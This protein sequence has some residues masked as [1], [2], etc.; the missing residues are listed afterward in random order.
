LD[1]SYTQ[2]NHRQCVEI[3]R[4]LLKSV[5][6]LHNYTMSKEFAGVPANISRQLQE[7]ILTAARNV[8]DGACRIIECS[9]ILIGNS[10]E[11]SLWQQLAT[12]TKSVSEAI[13]RLATSVKY[14]NVLI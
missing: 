5:D 7:P 14:V 4:V 8:V 9:K 13:K 11:A 3:S 12:H 10:K 6:E 1:G 2:D